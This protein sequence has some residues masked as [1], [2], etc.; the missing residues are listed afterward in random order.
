MAG[1]TLEGRTAVIIGGT[2]GIGRTMA[3]GLA[4]AGANVVATGR[5]TE[6]VEQV[7]AEVAARG[8]RTIRQAVD[9]ARRESIVA[10]EEAVTS[11]LGPP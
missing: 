2:S 6:L 11:E 8:R 4:E 7:A 3:I 1:I 5:R 9:V 10:L